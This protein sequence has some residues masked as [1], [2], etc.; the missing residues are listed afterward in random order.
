MTMESLELIFY[1]A[2]PH[3]IDSLQWRSFILLVLLQWR[4]FDADISC[5]R[6]VCIIVTIVIDYIYMIAMTLNLD[7][8]V[9]GGITKRKGYGSHVLQG[10]S[11]LNK[12]LC[13]KK[14]RT[15]ILMSVLGGKHTKNFM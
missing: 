11:L 14:E 10:W 6:I 1:V 2:G 7:M 13:L 8:L 15:A 3:K 5:S 9:I 4:G 12:R